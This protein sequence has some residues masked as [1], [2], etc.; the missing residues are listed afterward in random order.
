[1][2][3][4]KYRL[5]G[6]ELTL[7]PQRAIYFP[8]LHTLIISD[9]H[10]GKVNH[11]RRAGIPVPVAANDA[12]TETLIKLIMELK[13]DR[14]IFIGD[15]FHSSYNAEWEV[16][17]QVIKNFRSC[18]FELVPGNHDIL[19]GIQYERHGIKMLESH[20]P[21]TNKITLV[22]APIES[23]IEPVYYLSGHLHPAVTLSGKGRQSLT[24]PC[25]WFGKNQGLLP[26]F[27]VFT[28]MKSIRMS[29][30]DRVFAIASERVVEVNRS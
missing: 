7:L 16:L 14:V 13:P 10:L 22:H 29:E 30:G 21:L 2:A 4:A 5:E 11:F 17:G 12:N 9:L 27:G 3:I 26:A 28:G 19:G 6:E 20:Y 15:L 18:S 24:F 23:P 8:N 1:M 25:F